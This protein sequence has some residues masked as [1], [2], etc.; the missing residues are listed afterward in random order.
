MIDLRLL[1]RRSLATANLAAMASSA[2]LFGVLI[3][4][5]F[6]L[7]AV[8]GFSPV[9]LALA[10]T[11]IAG[12]FVLVAPLAGRA[13]MRVGSERLATA[14][15]LV[16]ASGAVWTGLAAPA[17]DYAA[18]LP[19]ILGLRRRPGD[20]HRRDHRDGDPRRAGRPAG[21]RLGAAEHQPLHR[22]RARRGHPRRD[23]ERPPARQPRAGAGAGGA[24]RAASWSPRASAPPCWSPPAS[25]CWPPSPPRACPAW[26]R[27]SRRPPC[28]PRSTRRCPSEGLG[29]PGAGAGD[30][31]P[32]RPRR[33]A[34]VRVGLVLRLAAA[35]P[36][37]V[38]RPRAGRRAH[39]AASGS[40]SACWC[41]AC[42]RRWRRWR[43]CAP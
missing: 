40:A 17:Q 38:R 37:P 5:P 34:R 27:P 7:T 21:R 4:L 22:R 36:G 8:L 1:R 26:S 6:Y 35:L 24:R 2:A 23:P 39:P 30:A 11:P 19:G 13:M 32:R 43:R 28:R 18:V 14:G 29:L 20:V 3:L 41:R 25:W 33:G 42:A 9:Q 12:S 15:F 16:A 10:I 31:G